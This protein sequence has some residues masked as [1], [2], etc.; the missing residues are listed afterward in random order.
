MLGRIESRHVSSYLDRVAGSQNS[1]TVCC[2][3]CTVGTYKFAGGW[4]LQ[5]NNEKPFDRDVVCQQYSI[6]VRSRCNIAIKAA[7]SR[8]RR[9][10]WSRRWSRCRCRCRAT[11]VRTGD[12]EIIAAERGGCPRSDDL[13]ISLNDNCVGIAG[14]TKKVRCDL[15]TGPKSGIDGPVRCVTC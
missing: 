10:C 9:W 15:S 12:R 11:Y 7:W 4:R 1:V 8:R 5:P 13:A 2:A 6:A 14:N 3:R